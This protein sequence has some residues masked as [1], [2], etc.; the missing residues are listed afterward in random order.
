MHRSGNGD[1]CKKMLFTAGN[2]QHLEQDYINEISWIKDFRPLFFCFCWQML[3]LGLIIFWPLLQRMFV[4]WCSNLTGEIIS[5]KI[6]N[7]LKGSSVHDTL[8]GNSTLVNSNFCFS[9]CKPTESKE[10]EQE[11][12]WPNLISVWQHSLMIMTPK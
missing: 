10:L 1:I 9:F 7:I 4:L 5:A 2:S 11:Q 3:I 6:A 12:V 8:T